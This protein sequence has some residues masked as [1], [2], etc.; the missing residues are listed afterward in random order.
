M[1]KGI[2]QP[3]H[4]PLNNFEVFILGLPPIVFITVAGLEEELETVDLPD[5]TTASGGNTK[6]VEWTGTTMLHHTVERLA[7]EA[8]FKEGQDS[9]TSTYK[10]IGTLLSRGIQNNVH[11]TYTLPGLYIMKRVIPDF[12][13]ANEGE[14][15]MLEWTFKA[16]DIIPV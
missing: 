10:K 2:I 16:D 7:L 4:A 13:K 11:A 9:V 14:P 1:L 6:P 12:D 15:A 3:N 8:W 5:R